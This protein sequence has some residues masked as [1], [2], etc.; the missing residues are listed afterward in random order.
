MEIHDDRLGGDFIV[1][2]T[3]LPGPDGRLAGSVHVAR[4]ITE[5]QRVERLYAV[6]S[7]VGEA[8][9]RIH[10]EQALYEEVCR[11]IAEAGQFPL[12]WIGLARGGEVSPVASSGL[13]TDYL[14]EIKVKVEGA[15]GRGPTGTCV[16][17]DRPVVNDDFD[18]NMTTAAWRESALRYAFRASAAF[19]LRRGA[20]A[21]GALTLYAARPGVFDAEHVRLLEALAA[22]LSY[23]LDAM[24][25]EGLRKAAE[26]ALR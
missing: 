12:V 18:T 10:D 20:Q 2:T 5:R 22:D 9:V 15:L 26:M 24:Q 16:R 21:V 7:Q 6:L 11:I 1:S 13:A 17:E 3:P 8:I 14:A 25:Q 4:D 19:P 23:A